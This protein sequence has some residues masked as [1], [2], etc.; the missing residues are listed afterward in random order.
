MTVENE[1]NKLNYDCLVLSEEVT[2]STGT[3]NIRLL[4]V[5]NMKTDILVKNLESN[6]LEII[7]YNSKDLTVKMLYDLP[8]EDVHIQFLKSLI[9]HGIDKSGTSTLV[10]E[11]E[12][13]EITD[14]L[15]NSLYELTDE[16]DEEES[17]IQRKK[18]FLLAFKHDEKIKEHILEIN[19][20][21]ESKA[22]TTELEEIKESLKTG[23][24]MK[25][26]LQRLGNYLNKVEGVILRKNINT[27]HKLD[28]STNSYEE[29]TIDELMQKVAILFNEKNLIND[30]DL[31]KAIHHITDRLE[32]V[33]DIVKFKN[34][35]YSMKEHKIIESDV[36][37]F[38]I[39]ECPYD[40][41]PEAKGLLI[42]KFLY[43]SLEVKGNPEE[44]K[45]KVKGVKQII[46]YLFKSGNPLNALFFI[47]GISGGGK[48]L[49]GN[50]LTSIFG[51]SEKVADIKLEKLESDNH[52]S[53]GLVGKHL[54]LIRD[55][56]N[57][58]ISNEGILKQYSG[59][60]DIP[61]N[62]KGKTPYSLNKD[63]VPKTLLVANNLPIF[64]N[65]SEGILQRLVII[66]FN[67]RFR[68]TEKEDPE[69]E[70]KILSNPSE[71]EYLI[72]SSL[73]AYKEMVS[74]KEDFI[75]RINEEKTLELLLKHSRPLEYIVKMLISKV[76]EEAS[77]TEEELGSG[78]IFTDELNRICLLIAKEKGIQIPL[79]NHGKVEPK[80][81]MT[82]IKNTFDLYD[83]VDSE[84]N[85]YSSKVK[86]D[87]KTNKNK[88]YYPYLIKSDLYK[89]FEGL[90]KS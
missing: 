86:K 39:I 16:E 77:K 27:I 57:P 61:I 65:I 10:M 44:T 36:P 83:F 58:V 85:P 42:D 46:G 17:L 15:L 55:S 22:L 74:N 54:N 80:K 81:L 52:S 90:V 9:N 3:Y 69:L 11:K 32:P 20:L 76:D 64:K 53:S 23:K 72:Y 26:G 4:F 73:Q 87:I 71:M 7:P 70:D 40:Y 21:L 30:K 88:R 14:K 19:E 2:D 67:I 13:T 8:E 59:N 89:E 35:L 49:F 37:V 18:Q 45:Q 60:E 1:L 82:S 41:N 56:N 43:D 31:E 84:G 68:G 34:C 38:T 62:P 28:R 63:Y 12:V 24:G 48:S 51:G 6:E 50:L 47:V 79:N 78:V 75:L 5:L 33:K 29:I 66:E 25:R